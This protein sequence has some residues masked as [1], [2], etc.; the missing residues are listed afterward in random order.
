MK[1]DFLKLYPKNSSSNAS[2]R[3]FK[4]LRSDNCY[5][6]ELSMICSE[7]VYL[8][9]QLVKNEARNRLYNTALEMNVVFIKNK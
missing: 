4:D 8:N 9:E 3:I 2:T 5:V 1:S 7:A 6:L